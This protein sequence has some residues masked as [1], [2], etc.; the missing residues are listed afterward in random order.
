MTGRSIG[1][2]HRPAT[3]L[4]LIF[5]LTFV[6]A[7]GVAGSELA[8]GIAVGH[9]AAAVGGF[10]LA[11][12]ATVWAWINYSWFAS[13]FDTDDW[14]FRVM[15]MV[16]M[17]GVIV[18][19]IGI[20]PIFASVD[21]GQPLDNHIL[22]AGYVIMRLAMVAQWLRA[23]HGDPK[24]RSIALT[25]AVF[26]TVAQIGW[27]MTAILPLDVT[28]TLLA[29]VLL[30]IL[31]LSGPLVAEA[32]GIKQGIGTT[33]WHPFHIAERYGL[34]AIIALGETVLGTLAAAQAI[35]G[36]AGWTIDAVVVIGAGVALTF[37][38]WWTY[39]LLP[40]AP[41]LAVRR[42]RA[43]PWGYGHVLVFGA[44]AAVGAGLHVIGY[45]FDEHYEVS[46]VTVIV[47]VAVPVLLYLASLFAIHAWL[48]SGLPR[49]SLSQVS[50]MLLPVLAIVLAA[51]GWP[52]WACLLVVLAS[53]VLL[54]VTYELGA[55][56]TLAAQLD[57]VLARAEAR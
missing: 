36:S 39:F 11:M 40:S 56:R 7:F 45:S 8:H 22:V 2:E 32:N 12:G 31:E 51:V 57:R 43:F 28:W 48:V 3:S 50:T 33:P 34:L 37:A 54:I 24:Y 35:S 44:I 15:T 21:Q 4:E 10:V 41:V 18:L 52:L 55:W 19:A 14:L 6:A 9:W 30:W 20:P 25:Y 49:N 23:A 29:A 42:D 46:T 5:D 26:V 13:A 27:V 53:P 47:S 16:Q 17:S 1:G 38:L